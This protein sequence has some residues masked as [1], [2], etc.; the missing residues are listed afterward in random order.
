MYR[1]KFLPLV[2]IVLLLAGLTLTVQ[3]QSIEPAPDAV[4]NP[5]ANISWPPPVYTLR[6]LFTIRGSANLPDMLNYFIEFRP[7][8]LPSDEPQVTPPADELEWSPVTLPSTAA[9]QD[10]IL[11]TWDTTLAP[12]GVYELRLTV[13]L[14]SGDPVIFLVSPLRIENTPPPF[15]VT[16][17]APPNIVA[18]PTLPTIE[19][20]A[21][22]ADSAPRATASAQSVN[23]RSGDSVVYPQVGFLLQGESA[24]IVGI[25]S[26][27]T[28]WLYVELSNGR[29]GFVSPSVVTVSGDTSNLPRIDPPPPP[30]PTPIPATAT[31]IAT[32][33][34]VAGNPY[35]DPASPKCNQVINLYLDVANFGS[36]ANAVTGTISVQDFRVQD[37]TFQTGTIGVVPIIQPGQ[38]LK[39][40]PIPLTVGTYYNEQHRIIF[41]IDANNQIPET[42]ESNNTREAL[43]TLEKAS[44]S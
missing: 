1:S 12:D 11:G 44:C 38:T 39:V 4:I 35:F 25:S 23:V 34:L 19:T 14:S 15:A 17:I 33:D 13:N 26:F 28:G 10:D 31:P 2:M 7:L 30:T 27:G 36:T 29:R 32:T 43:Y 5:N 20:I 9:V 18:T 21:P 41:T 22:T 24:P 37:G 6:G 8:P 16:P 3:A 42:N 40:G